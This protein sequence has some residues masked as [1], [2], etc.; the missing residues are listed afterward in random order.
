MATSVRRST[1]TYFGQW[2]HFHPHVHAL[3]CEGMFPSDGTFVPLLSE[4][5]AVLVEEG[6]HQRWGGA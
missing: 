1:F 2:V 5:R 4:V 3:V 6:D